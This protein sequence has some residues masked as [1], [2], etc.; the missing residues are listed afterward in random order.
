MQ[1]Q[2]PTTCPLLYTGRS[3]H[4]DGSIRG[5]AMGTETSRYDDSD[6][7]GCGCGTG[8]GSG[9]C[10]SWTGF[11]GSHTCPCRLLRLGLVDGG[12][13]VEGRERL[14]LDEE[15]CESH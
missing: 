14:R 3:R 8:S 12:D 13:V 2:V 11:G 5:T 9:S 10:G 6:S 15:E 1:R 7:D 4:F